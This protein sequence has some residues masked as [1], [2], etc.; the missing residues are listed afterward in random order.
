MYGD[1]FFTG[2]SEKT[3]PKVILVP[4]YGGGNNHFQE[5]RRDKVMTIKTKAC[6]Q[7]PEIKTVLL[8]GRL[9]VAN[10]DV[11]SSELL[12]IIDESPAG[13]IL[14][15]K[16]VNFVSSAGLRI[17]IVAYK[18][19]TASGKKIAAVH[20]RPSVYKIFKLASLEDLLHIF[21]SEDAAIQMLGP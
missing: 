21:D 10:A 1:S 14:D 15:L 13:I 5:H 3:G 19:A 6:K 7:F 12:K 17:L 18:H 16:D 20:V 11:L 4:F 2:P 9:D 8:T